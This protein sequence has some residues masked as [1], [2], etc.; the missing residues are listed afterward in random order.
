[1]KINTKS[2]KKLNFKMIRIFDESYK[3]SGIGN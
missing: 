1:M 2:G 3:E